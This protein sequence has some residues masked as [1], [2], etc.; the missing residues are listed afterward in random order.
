[1]PKTVY[2]AKT[3]TAIVKA[4]QAARADGKT[5]M[6]AF[7]AAKTVGYKGSLQGIT[8]MIRDVENKAGKPKGKPGRP[9]KAA[10][11]G[12][13]GPG[14]PPKAENMIKRGPGRP[15]KVASTGVSSIEAMVSK[16]VKERVNGI[17]NR[18]IAVLEQAKGW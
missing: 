1:M 3:K 6:Q 16:F 14:R 7:D 13:R 11:K 18:A 5:W 17:L 2:D 12:R 8:K 10:T 9:P 4:A 15:R